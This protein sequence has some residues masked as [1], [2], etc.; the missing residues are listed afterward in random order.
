MPFSGQMPVKLTGAKAGAGLTAQSIQYTFVKL[1]ADQTVVPVTA[2]TDK[3]IGVIQ[4]PVKATG[5]EVDVVVVGETMIQADAALAFGYG[6]GPAADGQARRVE[7][8]GTIATGIYYC[9]GMV[10]N[11]VGGSSAGNLITAVINCVNAPMGRTGP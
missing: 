2:A 7:V 1:S 9:C 10:V 5:D 11:V 3:P 6:I 4:A 8:D